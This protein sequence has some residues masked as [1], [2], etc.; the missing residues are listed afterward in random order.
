MPSEPEDTV[1]LAWKLMVAA[2]RTVMTRPTMTARRAL[3]AARNSEGHGGH[4]DAGRRRG[5]SLGEHTQNPSAPRSGRALP[6]STG[7]DTAQLH[8]V[9]ADMMPPSILCAT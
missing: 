2:I 7:R 6:R 3:A 9:G 1:R 5:Q 8:R 4:R